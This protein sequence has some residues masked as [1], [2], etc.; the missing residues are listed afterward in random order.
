MNNKAIGYIRVS[1]TG[2]ADS[3]VSL[4]A[5]RAKIEAYAVMHE[6]NLSIIEDAG[7]SA[8]SLDRPGMARLLKLIQ[9]RKVN[10]VVVSKIDRISRSISDLNNLI[11]LFNKSGVEFVSISDHIDTGSANGRLSINLL[12]SI[13]QWEREII[14]ERTSEALAVMRSNGKRISRFAP[15]G[16]KLNGN[17]VVEDI[18]EQ[19]AIQAIHKLRQDGLSLRRIGAEL[20]LR[21]FCSRSGSVL[22]AQ[23][24]NTVLKRE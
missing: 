1:T 2:Q 18:D 8:K 17:G 10:T 20:S 24:I 6:L 3:G 9:G 13:N 21:G 14:S 11:Q 4:E 16:F 5:Q 19:K 12:G 22:S 15:Y 7:I 23:T